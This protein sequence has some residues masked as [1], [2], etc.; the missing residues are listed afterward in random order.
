MNFDISPDQRLLL[1]TVSSFVRKESPVSRA[2]KLREDPLGYAKQTWRHMG[3]LGWLGIMYP[4]AAGGFG[5]SF[6]DAALIIEQLGT[7][8]VPEPFVPSVVLGGTAL[9]EAGTDEQRERFLAP[10]IAGETSLALAYAERAGRYDT[11]YC[12]TRAE[13][14]GDGYTLRGEKVFVLNGHAAE[15]LIVSARTSGAASDAD[16]ISLFIVDRESVQ[17]R[18]IQLL[19]G[20]RGAIITLAGAT[21][22]KD[23]LLGE[24]GKAGALLD[25]LIDLG[26]AAACAEGVGIMRTVLEMTG[27][28][29][30][31]REQFGVKIGSFQA[32]QHRLVDMFVETEVAK[33]ASIMASLKIDEPDVIERAGA[34]SAAKTQLAQSGRFVTQQGIQLHGGIGIT[35]EHD[36]GLYFK[37]MQLLLS[38]FGDEEHHVAR[39]ASLPSFL[40]DVG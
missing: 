30:R 1:E 33:S 38:L 28:Y 35:D 5:G 22:G 9:S 10:A 3:E 29:L 27:D 34:I 23:R 4:E 20:R 11:A 16:G 36:I 18:A 14:S 12:E 25:K 7:Q 6:V 40:R 15:Q 8:L 13:R 26:A 17:A 21:V 19:D 32:L 39:F 2:R 37:R 24:E 31:T